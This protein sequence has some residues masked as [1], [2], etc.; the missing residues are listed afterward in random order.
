MNT[1]VTTTISAISG[2]VI[3]EGVKFIFPEIQKSIKDRRDARKIII[4]N[5]DPLLKSADELL[6]KIHSLAKSDFKD[7]ELLYQQNTPEARSEILYTLYLF[8][9]FYA[10]LSI[11]RKRK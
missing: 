4:E 9:A 3:W 1:I 7:Y 2:T 11:I 8:S 5:I 6:G 10:R